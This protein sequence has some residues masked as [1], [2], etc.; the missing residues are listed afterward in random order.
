MNRLCLAECPNADLLYDSRLTTVCPSQIVIDETH[1]LA[2][3]A[4][5]SISFHPLRPLAL[6]VSGS[7]HFNFSN[8][9]TTKDDESSSGDDEID[10]ADEIPLDR[11]RVRSTK[12]SPLPLDGS[13]KIWEF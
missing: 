10:D 9:N 4:V 12:S 5:G 6:S 8:H 7:R 11:V 3:D 1:F 13:T 2:L